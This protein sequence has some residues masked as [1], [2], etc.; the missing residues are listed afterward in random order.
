MRFDQYVP[1]SDGEMLLYIIACAVILPAI[2]F[3]IEALIVRHKIDVRTTVVGLLMV[4]A[5]GGFI[6]GLLGYHSN[7]AQNM[8]VFNSNVSQK[9]DVESVSFAAHQNKKVKDTQKPTDEGDLAVKV[10]AH[11]KEHDAT[12][13]QDE[14][15]NEPTFKNPETGQPLTD[16]L[17]EK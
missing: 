9:Y 8:E 5:G 16:F 12:L 6:G 17:K 2:F 4:A 10:V 13:T 3:G 14:K 7:D 11:G 15:T 1:V